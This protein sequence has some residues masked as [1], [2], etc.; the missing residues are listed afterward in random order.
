MTDTGKILILG[1]SGFVG[2]HMF[3]RL[4]PGRAIAATYSSE[5]ENSVHFDVF[6]MSLADIIS[7]PA[8]V[9]HA[10]VFFGETH[11]DACVADRAHSQRLNVDCTKQ[12]IDQLTQ[13]RIPLTF[14]SSEFVFDGRNGRNVEDSPAN[15]I[16][17]YGRQKLEIEAYLQGSD[18]DWTVMRLGKVYAADGANAKLFTGWIEDIEAARKIRVA[19]DQVVSPILVNDVVSGCLLAAEKKVRGL[20]HLCGTKPHGR[21]MLL[22]ML[23]EEMRKYRPVDVV[24]E[25]CSIDDFNLPEP[26]PKDCSMLPDKLVAA[27]GLKITAVEDVCRET[28]R[29]H[30]EGS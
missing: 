23:I 13:W 19:S 9:S 3:E 24:V 30:F 25:K 20:F 17:L 2:G 11:P 8:S 7:D 22:E 1:A 16:N 6:T 12:V 21:D 15:P 29:Q 28:V 18:A 10:M 14:T 27:T 4:G 5:L 26:R